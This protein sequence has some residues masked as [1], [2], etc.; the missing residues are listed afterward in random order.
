M[1]E[2]LA[3]TVLNIYTRPFMKKVCQP[4]TNNSTWGVA[5]VNELGD[6]WVSLQS[7]QAHLV[8]SGF[9]ET[10]EGPASLP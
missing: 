2:A 6:G 1:T 9:G 5:W 8:L 3:R 4:R 10:P 7:P